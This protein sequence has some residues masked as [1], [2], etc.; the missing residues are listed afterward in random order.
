MLA[1]RQNALAASEE[2]DKRLAVAV[3]RHIAKCDD[4]EDSSFC[5]IIAAR[6]LMLGG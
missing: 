1:V 5:P 2:A 3:K 4:Y 6:Q